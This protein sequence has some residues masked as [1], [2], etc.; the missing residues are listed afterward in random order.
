MSH[1]ELALL[2]EHTQ[3]PARFRFYSELNHKITRWDASCTRNALKWGVAAAIALGAC[4]WVLRAF[5]A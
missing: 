1:L 5:V 4:V 3:L 2:R